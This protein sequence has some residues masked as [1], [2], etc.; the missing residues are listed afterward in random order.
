MQAVD[1]RP[2]FSVVCRGGTH[3]NVGVSSLDQTAIR[4]SVQQKRRSLRE[5]GS[6]IN[7][8]G[9]LHR[10]AAANDIAKCR[11]ATDDVD[12]QKCVFVFV[13]WRIEQE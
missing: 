13:G 11:T 1:G 10:T 7:G 4:G 9:S 5:P 8:D 6:R 3:Q 12:R 2:W